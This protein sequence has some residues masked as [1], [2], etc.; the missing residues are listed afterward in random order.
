LY[1]E[2]DLD[3]KFKDEHSRYFGAMKWM[4]PKQIAPV[5]RLSGFLELNV[6]EAT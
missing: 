4:R 3:E 5:P 2:N 6:K 1:F